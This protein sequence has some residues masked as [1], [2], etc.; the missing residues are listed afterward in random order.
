MTR[1][2]RYVR[3]AIVG[4][5]LI[6]GIV[7]LLQR[8]I[9]YP[10]SRAERLPAAAF[11]LLRQLFHSATDIELKTPDNIRIRGWHLQKNPQPAK[12]LWLLFHGNGGHRAGRGRWYQLAAELNCDVLAMDYHGYGDSEGR[13]SEENL[14]NDAL[15]AWNYARRQL[16]V[17]PGQ[18]LIIGESLGGAVAVQLAATASA[19][20]EIPKALVLTST[21]DSMTHAASHHF[22]LFPIRWILADRWESDRHI[23]EVACRILQFHGDR[24]EV[25]PL[26]LGRR[27]HELAPA[28]SRDGIAK[29]FVLLP[30]SRHNDLLIREANTISRQIAAIQDEPADNNR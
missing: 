25:V 14:R 23:S 27:L 5:L 1:L 21:F 6:V 30:G 8:R 16:A 19:R 18:I 28:A 3:L 4:F 22:P 20:G 9:M 7:A 29:N 15:A 13:P 26:P 24:D 11:P 12:H 17:A 10:A 2:I